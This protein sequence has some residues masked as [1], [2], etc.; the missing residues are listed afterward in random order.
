[1]VCQVEEIQDVVA[2]PLVVALLGAAPV[3]FQH[4][5]LAAVA[6]VT[7]TVAPMAVGQAVAQVAH[8][9]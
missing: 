3:M 6:D 1:M 8:K 2:A 5:T 4:Q 9:L 7:Q